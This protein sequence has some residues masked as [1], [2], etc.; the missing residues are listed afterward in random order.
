MTYFHVIAGA[1]EK[2]AHPLVRKIGPADVKVA[3]ARGF[4]DFWAM[5][6]HLLFIGMIYPIAGICL[7]IFTSDRNAL[8]LLYP[9]ASGFALV[10]P[11]AAIGLYEISRRRE[12]GFETSWR[13]ALAVRRSPA[14]PSI[15]ALGL[16]L[17]A[18]FLAWLWVA[19]GLYV[20][21]YGPTPP[22][23]YGALIA[24]A[25]TT[26][27]GWTLILVGNAVGFLFALAV[28]AVSV[29][30]FPLMLDRD[31]GLAVAVATSVRVI[32]ANPLTMAL[33]GLVIA[34][35]LA[36]G[37]LPF[38][39]GLAIVMPALAHA[40]WHLYRRVVGPDQSEAIRR[41]AA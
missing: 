21:L 31:V 15:L 39:A 33:W 9:L 34:A 16:L 41:S 25:F 35:A 22:E 30:S 19:R 2:P 13:H 26:S 18:L 38:F 28:L 40:S 12:L 17:V 20:W 11:F 5:P 3:L 37:T 29:V 6:S 27:R 1:G 7:A 10:A 32:G 4:D 23:S 14:I 24:Q 36:I 8:P